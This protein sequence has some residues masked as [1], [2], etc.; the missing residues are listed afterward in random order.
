LV[1]YP[2]ILGQYLHHG[3]IS[4]FLKT[5]QKY[6]TNACFGKILMPSSYDIR[7]RQNWYCH[8]QKHISFKKT[9]FFYINCFPSCKVLK[10]WVHIS[11]MGCPNRARELPGQ[12]WMGVVASLRWLSPS[13]PQV[14]PRVSLW[15]ILWA[16]ASSPLSVRNSF[17]HCSSSAHT[18]FIYFVPSLW[19]PWVLCVSAVSFVRE[20]GARLRCA[21]AFEKCV[22]GMRS[23]SALHVASVLSVSAPWLW[24][25]LHSDALFCPGRFGGTFAKWCGFRSQL[26]THP[27]NL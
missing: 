26:S 16:L 3:F 17:Y 14:A 13:P 24:F 1:S 19:V 18:G 8:K 2:S 20:G 12:P 4:K 6:S 5:I 9:N 22:A 11:F 7:I 15:N 10:Y 23:R 27:L 25:F 21:R